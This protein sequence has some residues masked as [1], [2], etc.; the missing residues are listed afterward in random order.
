MFA[1]STRTKFVENKVVRQ[2]YGIEVYGKVSLAESLFGKCRPSFLGIGSKGFPV[3]ARLGLQFLA[4][5]HN[6]KKPFWKKNRK[7]RSIQTR[8]QAHVHLLM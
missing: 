2:L 6:F 5:R 3:S 4:I 1:T 8:G 7:K